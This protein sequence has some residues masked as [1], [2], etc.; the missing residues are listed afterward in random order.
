MLVRP[1]ELAN[2]CAIFSS[3]RS[4]S[5]SSTDLE[6]L[7]DRSKLIDSTASAEDIVNGAVCAGLLTIIGTECCTTEFGRE[8]G[9]RQNTP[10]CVMTREAQDHFIKNVLLN[11]ESA[12]WCCGEFLFK[13]HVDS[14]LGT[15]A[16]ERKHNES[17]RD[18]KWLMLLSDVKLI[19]VTKD[20]ALVSSKYLGYIN[21][22]LADARNAQ[23]D[24]NESA[25]NENNE[26][27]ALAESLALE[28]ER[29]RLKINN[30]PELAELV[31]Q[32]SK[33]D[34]S[35]GYDIQSFMGTEDDPSSDLLIE[36]KGTKRQDLRFIWTQNERR[37]AEKEQERYCI[38]GYTNVDL[39]SKQA[40]GPIKIQN[41]SYTLS[42]LGYATIPLDILV[43]K[44]NCSPTNE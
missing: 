20:R 8:L 12:E 5:I 22:F 32:I 25:E 42:Q 26:I 41:P 15:F 31:Q 40:T 13:F 34:W 39:G 1:K 44:E 4:N 37:V 43:T 23:Q 3:I 24:E 27:G 36:V 33:V 2:L 38:Y 10:A 6:K 29:I 14:I 21:N 18:I 19:E 35:A 11:A 9:R 17:P 30:L 16:Y 28:H 7:A